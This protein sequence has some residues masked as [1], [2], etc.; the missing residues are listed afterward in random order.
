M[1]RGIP[2][3]TQLNEHARE[4]IHSIRNALSYIKYA[5]VCSWIQSM[6]IYTINIFGHARTEE[7]SFNP[8]ETNALKKKKN[9]HQGETKLFFLFRKIGSIGLRL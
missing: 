5:C 3:A 8:K 7:R 2:S 4:A 6:Y 1:R 9:T